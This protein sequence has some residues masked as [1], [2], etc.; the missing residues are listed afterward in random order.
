[1]AIEL[2]DR[3]LP[4]VA[5][6]CRCSAS[7]TL[8]YL[9]AALV[10][11]PH[12]IWATMSALIVCQ[13][14]LDAT[15]ASLKWRIL[16][17]LI[18]IGVGL[19]VNLMTAPFGLPLAAQIALS[20]AIGAIIAHLKPDVRVCMWTGPI[21]L[22]TGSPSEP[23]ALVALYRGSEVM[24]GALVGG[25]MHAVSAFLVSKASGGRGG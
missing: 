18:G 20:V 23:I 6:V 5:F 3:A 25:A 12:P 14:T 10:G 11:L 15:K 21:V 8:A 24:M 2:S 13:E 7:A 17:T 16:G 4:A 19:A 1:M 22:L 9:A